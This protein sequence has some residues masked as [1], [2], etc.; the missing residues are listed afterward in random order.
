[1]SNEITV[2]RA[3]K[4]RLLKFVLLQASFRIAGCGGGGGRG[5]GDTGANQQAAAPQGAGAGRRSAV[6]RCDDRRLGFSVDASG[7]EGKTEP[8]ASS[9]RGRPARAVLHR[10]RRESARDRHGDAERRSA[11]GAAPFTSARSRRDAERRRSV[12]RQPGQSA[13]R[14]RCE[15]GS[16][17]RHRARCQRA[18]RSRARRPPAARRSISPGAR[19]VREGSGRDRGVDARSVALAAISRRCSR[20]SARCSV[21]DA[22]AHC[23][24]ARRRRARRGESPEEHGVRDPR[25]RPDGT[26]VSQLLAEV[27]VGKEPRFV[28][29]S[30]DDTRAYVTNAVDGTMSVIDLT[31]RRPRWSA[32]RCP[33]AS[34]RAAS[35]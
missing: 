5:D 17:R 19:C 24:D 31:A 33:S 14:A 3:R 1:M 10:Q 29:L 7:F 35:R 6:H 27:P 11:G 21:R 25:A 22:R 12:P 15:R 30:P 20:S 9:F 26:D 8:A 23:A 4:L 32:R 28:A 16:E 2:R 18:G 34:S 13:R